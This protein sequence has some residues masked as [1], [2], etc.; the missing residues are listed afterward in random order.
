MRSNKRRGDTDRSNLKRI[1]EFRNLVDIDLVKLGGALLRFLFRVD[2]KLGRDLPA[3]A[4]PVGVKI[5][6]DDFAAG[7]L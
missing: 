4:T 2:F 7:N 5:D 1:G 6:K 3:W